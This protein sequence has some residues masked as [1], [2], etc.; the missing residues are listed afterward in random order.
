[1]KR[2]T[3]EEMKSMLVPSIYPRVTEKSVSGNGFCHLHSHSS[4][5][6][7]SF[8][9]CRDSVDVD[10]NDADRRDKSC[11]QKRFSKK[12]TNEELRDILEPPKLRENAKAFREQSFAID[13]RRITQENRVDN[14]DSPSTVTVIRPISHGDGEDSFVFENRPLTGDDGDY[15]RYPVEYGESLDDVRRNGDDDDEHHFHGGPR[16][17]GDVFDS[18]TN[19][20]DGFLDG[21]VDGC[22]TVTV[23]KYTVRY[24]SETGATFHGNRVGTLGVVLFVFKFLEV[25]ILH[26]LT[27]GRASELRVVLNYVMTSSPFH[28]IIKSIKIILIYLILFL[29]SFYITVRYERPDK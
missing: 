23:E 28:I 1:M 10:K 11:S 25:F 12:Y 2:L 22:W 4:L 27:G 16:D 9:T 29:L 7:A 21:Q 8:M 14:G 24:D 17:N 13:D 3:S 5:N 15:H 20:N 19:D 6:V 18:R 26:C